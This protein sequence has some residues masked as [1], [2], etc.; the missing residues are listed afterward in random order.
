MLNIGAGELILI[1]V[2]VL[3]VFGPGK[4]PEVAKS[5]GKA[6]REFRKASSNLQR[7]WDEVTREDTPVA[8]KTAKSSRKETSASG[9]EEKN[10][11]DDS[12]SEDSTEKHTEQTEAEE[13]EQVEPKQTEQ[14][15][16]KGEETQDQPV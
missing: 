1:L 15:E 4:L 9:S 13:A 12:G 11:G 2:V 10:S 6:M 14:A 16:K 5:M 8:N 7:V 3:I